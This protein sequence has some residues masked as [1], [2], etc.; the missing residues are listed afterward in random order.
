ML[1]HGCIMYMESWSESLVL[2][3]DTAMGVAHTPM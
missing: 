1:L 3:A 2:L